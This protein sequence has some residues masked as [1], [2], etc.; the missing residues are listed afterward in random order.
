[1]S[2]G[3]ADSALFR[4]PPADPSVK[5]QIDELGLAPIRYVDPSGK[6]TEAYPFNPNGSPDGIAALCSP[7]GRHLAL[8][9]HPER[10]FLGWQLPYHQGTGITV[11]EQLEV[12]PDSL[13]RWGP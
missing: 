7:D 13:S 11:R 1:M 10:C 3:R 4:I 9:P 6:T 2:T 5:A 12:A 8:M